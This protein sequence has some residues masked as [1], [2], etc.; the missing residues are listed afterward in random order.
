[1]AALLKDIFS[2]A[3]IAELS[4]RFSLSGK[5]I[6]AQLFTQHVYQNNWPEQTLTQRVAQISQAFYSQLQKKPFTEQIQ[7]LQQTISHYPQAQHG[8]LKLLPFVHFIG[9]Y[10]LSEPEKSLPALAF[11]TQYAS[12]E[13]AIRNFL[14]AHPEQTLEQMTQWTKHPSVH[15]RRLAS[16]GSRPLLPWGKVLRQLKANPAPIMHVLETLAQDSEPNVR[17]SVAN[18]L[19]DISK[20]HPNIALKFAQ[21]LQDQP[22]IIKH[23]LRHLLKQSEPRALALIGITAATHITLQNFEYDKRI[24]LGEKLNFSFQLHSPK[25][26]GALRLEYAIGFLR[27]SGQHNFKRFQISSKESREHS[28]SVS[29]QHDFKLL[30]SRRYYAGEQVLQVYVNGQMVQEVRFQL[31]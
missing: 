9:E 29:K 10:G 13:F 16:E 27:S 1:M 15:V 26:L 14:D 2:E 25:T 3:F 17:K 22:A 6:N 4:V 11:F 28:L 31:L 19:N 18:H 21:N 8:S 5:A 7:I 24:N 30:S 23:G 12:A 20:T